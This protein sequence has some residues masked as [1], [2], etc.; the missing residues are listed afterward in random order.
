MVGAAWWGGWNKGGEGLALRGQEEAIIII[1]NCILIC[2]S[3]KLEK[4]GR[5]FSSFSGER[6]A[7]NGKGGPQQAALNPDS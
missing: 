6:E 1:G 5:V 3:A 7:K 4:R 2:F